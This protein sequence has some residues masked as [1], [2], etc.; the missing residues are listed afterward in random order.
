[1]D[2]SLIALGVVHNSSIKDALIVGHDYQKS[3]NM[4]GLANGLQN[5][6]NSN[7]H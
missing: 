1:M 4:K 5:G 2:I 7:F 3:E 6:R